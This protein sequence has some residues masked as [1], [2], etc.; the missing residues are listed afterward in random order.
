MRTLDAYIVRQTFRPL[1]IAILIALLLLLVERMLR[2]HQLPI[3]STTNAIS[4]NGRYLA[5]RS[6]F[7]DKTGAT[8]KMMY[9]YDLQ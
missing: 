9:I 3:G 5:A 1:S 2:L 7:T 8:T 4:P 6:S